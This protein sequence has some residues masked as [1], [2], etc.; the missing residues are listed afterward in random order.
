[1]SSGAHYD[2]GKAHYSTGDYKAAIIEFSSAIQLFRYD[3]DADAAS[4]SSSVGLHILYSNRCACHIQL[5]DNIAALSDAKKSVEHSP[6][7]YF[8]G[9]SRLGSCYYTLKM[10]RDA[11]AAYEKVLEMDHGNAEALKMVAVLKRGIGNGSADDNVGSSSGG[12]GEG[13]AASGG[14]IGDLFHA[15]K[16]T[17]S[18]WISEAVS[19]FYFIHPDQKPY[20]YMGG[21]FLCMLL[22]KFATSYMF[23]RRNDS[24]YDEDMPPPPADS[25]GGYRSRY[26][27]SSSSSSS[28]GSS[29]WYS[30]Y[31]GGYGLSTSALI[32]IMVGGWFIPPLIPNLVGPE[33]ARP[34]FGMSWM[35]FMWLVRMLF[36]GGGGAGFYFGG[37]RRRRGFF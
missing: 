1:M 3:A 34:F 26:S 16:I 6:P 10:T 25:Y 31:N 9:Y 19:F 20:Y 2:L 5:K 30:G 36:G 37:N 12:G 21:A 14:G 7:G 17:V 33:R 24:I 32:M 4:S 8:K 28:Y 35:T 18:K 15:V 29:N 13:G 11:I 22:L 27:S 23:S